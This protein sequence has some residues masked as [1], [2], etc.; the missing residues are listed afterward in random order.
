MSISQTGNDKPTGIE[1]HHVEKFV[2][3]GSAPLQKILEPLTV[4]NA[5]SFEALG[6]NF[7]DGAFGFE[8][9]INVGGHTLEEGV[10]LVSNDGH[11][12]LFRKRKGRN[13][14]EAGCKQRTYC[15]DNGETKLQGAGTD[16]GLH[17]ET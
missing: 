5:G 9:F 2:S 1:S 7:Q 12:L 4:L 15:H 10:L 13:G 8:V 6:K 14:H 11:H 3:Q 16:E 17:E